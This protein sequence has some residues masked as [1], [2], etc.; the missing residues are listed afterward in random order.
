MLR[1]FLACFL[2][3]M[4]SLG[5]DQL[6]LNYLTRVLKRIRPLSST[7]SPLPVP[8]AAFECVAKFAWSRFKVG[9][10]FLIT[11]LLIENASP[12]GLSLFL[13]KNLEVL[14]LLILNDILNASVY[15]QFLNMGVNFLADF[16]GRVGSEKDG[17]KAMLTYLNL[18]D[19]TD[20]ELS[21]KVG[22]LFNEVLKKTCLINL[23]AVSVSVK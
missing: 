12:L 13:Y 14:K 10:M 11:E 22:Q 3:M 15:I 18:V 17:A 20:S 5:D 8:A 9:G 4:G 6:V 21:E 7:S 16:A 2:E 23:N 1:A 19:V